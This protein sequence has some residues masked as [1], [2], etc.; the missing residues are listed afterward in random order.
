MTAN[1]FDGAYPMEL[2]ASD[3]NAVPQVVTTYAGYLRASTH[4]EPEVSVTGG[5]AQV[6]VSRSGRTLVLAFLLRRQEWA[7]DSAEL[8][9]GEQARTF[10]RRELARA[11]AALLAT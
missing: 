11:V 9:C 10:G 2:I 6:S 5:R 3:G 7:L 4:A 8:R 1:W